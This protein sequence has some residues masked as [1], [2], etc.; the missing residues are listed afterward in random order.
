MKHYLT[1]VILFIFLSNSYAQTL[2]VPNAT[3]SGISNSLN[4]NVGIG[5]SSPASKLD[6][7]TSLPS[8]GLYESQLWSTSIPGYGLR[9]Q[10]GWDNN[11]ISQRLVQKFANTDYVSFGFYQGNVGVGT[12]SP[13]SRFEV[14]SSMPSQGTYE[15]QAWTTSTSGYSLRLQTAWDN[16]GISQRLIQKFAGTDYVSLAFYQGNVGIGT[17]VPDA[18]LAV[19]GSIHTNEVKV[20]LSVPGP[21]YVFESAYNL[22][23]LDEVSAYIKTNKHL[24]DVP[25][26]RDMEKNGLNLGEM[27]MLL[28]RKIE[29]LMLYLLEMKGQHDR[30][31]KENEK[32]RIQLQQQ[33]NELKAQ[34]TS[35]QGH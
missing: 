33:V 34:M 30:A 15:S 23:T 10:T 11:G 7:M 31:E 14:F 17:T 35:M 2:Y 19:K 32:Q 22:P 4:G 13:G 16:N 6:V 26:A 12:V 3:T 20:D 21:D 24:P 1:S 25:S 29:E 27:N 18:K 8:Q 9:L 5:I 28:L